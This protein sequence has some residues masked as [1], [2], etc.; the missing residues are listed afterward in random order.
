[1]F[2]S[3]KKWRGKYIGNYKIIER[4]GEGRYGIS[5]SATTNR[6][7]PVV[8][9]RFKPR[10][11]KKNKQKN[12]YEAVILS[13]INYPAIP[14]LL[15]IINE[16]NFYG[17]VLEQKP[18]TTL[19]N[20]LFKQKV[21]FTN[22]DI[23]NIGCQLIGII[24]YLHGKG[25]VHRDLRIPNVLVDGS[26]VSLIDFGLARWADGDRYH[27]DQDFSY[28]GDLLLFLHYSSFD[29]QK[30]ES[31]PWFVELNL[32]NE[33]IYFYKRMLRLEV[34]YS[35]IY[36]VEKDFLAAFPVRFLMN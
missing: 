35:T 6:G 9:K 7:E 29:K 14:K 21:I 10:I 26:E 36:E 17:F 24:K 19:E 8:I 15:G 22:S 27:Y 3:F 25:I 16:N 12:A 13:Q 5:Y 31:Q 34:P 18:G 33:Q 2:F 23:F 30:R 20:M 28:L 32:T 1:M 4:L 11:F